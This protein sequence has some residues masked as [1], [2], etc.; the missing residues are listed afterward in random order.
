MT[1]L[2][3]M[4]EFDANINSGEVSPDVIELL[5]ED[6]GDPEL[7]SE[8]LREN[9]GRPEVIKLIFEH[10]S[11]PEEVRTKAGAALNLPAKRQEEIEQLK[12]EDFERRSRETNEDK[13]LRLVAKIKKLNVGEKIRLAARANKE[14]RTLLLKDS[15]KQVVVS[16][17]EN[18][19][20]TESEAE[21]IAK[22]RQIPEEALR[23]IGKNKEFVKNYN[24]VHALVTNPKT[25]AGVSLSF[26]PR[27][28]EKDLQLLDKNKNVPEAVRTGA[29][30]ILMGKKK[31]R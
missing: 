3:R 25:P 12:K 6:L 15:N 16:V 1:A 29:K 10:P 2:D 24:V 18:P 20:L 14:L 19:R 31:T 28:K 27:I 9:L 21:L 22:S 23:S 30:R 13:E 4:E 26:L 5:L 17:V 8:L 7:Y 11:T